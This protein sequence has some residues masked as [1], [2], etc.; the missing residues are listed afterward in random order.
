MQ[1]FV[2]VKANIPLFQFPFPLLVP[3]SSNHKCMF[4][5]LC[6]IFNTPPKTTGSLP[7]QSMIVK[8]ARLL[9][10]LR[11][12]LSS[13]HFH[14]QLEDVQKSGRTDTNVCCG[15]FGFFSSSVCGMFYLGRYR[16]N[17]RL[18]G[19]IRAPLKSIENLPLNSNGAQISPQFF[20]GWGE[21]EKSKEYKNQE[22]RLFSP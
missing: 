16:E 11:H 5:S 10:T 2:T 21:E 1:R 14:V 8:M 22:A 19:E 7:C 9:Q 17:I 20:W 4:H 12:V 18:K 13:K 6:K 15:V 3:Q